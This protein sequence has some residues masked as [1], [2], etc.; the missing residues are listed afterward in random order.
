MANENIYV[1]HTQICG[2]QNLNDSELWLERKPGAMC[3]FQFNQ[4][5]GQ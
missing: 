4:T 2:K 1:I 3:P 5:A